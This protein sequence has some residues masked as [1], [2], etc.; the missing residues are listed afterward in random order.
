MNNNSFRKLIRGLCIAATVFCTSCKH[1]LM[2]GAGR[3]QEYDRE[4]D[5]E[6]N[7]L[8]VPFAKQT[9]TLVEV[10]ARYDKVLN[11]DHIRLGFDNTGDGVA[12]VHVEYKPRPIKTD[13]FPGGIDSYVI[14]CTRNGQ[15]MTGDEILDLAGGNRKYFY[16][17]G[18]RFN[19]FLD[20]DPL[21]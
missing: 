4:Y 11:E 2:C 14:F 1:D 9:H 20:K 7:E 15:K 6:F 13:E 10:G 17:N 5:R 12:D 18:A 21:R 3:H 16:F 19:W 8:L